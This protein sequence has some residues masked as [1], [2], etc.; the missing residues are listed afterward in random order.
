MTLMARYNFSF[1]G[2]AVNGYLE[3]PSSSST[4][5]STACL[6]KANLCLVMKADATS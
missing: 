2:S 4:S 3:G 6:M 1:V 5:I